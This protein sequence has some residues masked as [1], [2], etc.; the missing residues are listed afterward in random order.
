MK[1]TRDYLISLYY[2]LERQSGKQPTKQ[3]WLDSSSTPSDMPI[4]I[5]FGNWTNFVIACGRE[6]LKSEIS[7]KARLNSVKARKGK[8]GGNN[9]GGKYID[10]S[11]YVQI[12]NPNH[13]N[14]KS[15]GYMHEHRLVMS[16][17]LKRPLKK[18]EN[19]H[20]INGDRADNRIENLE[21]WTTTQPSGQ[22]VKD[23]INWA[24]EFLKEYG[25][26]VN[27][28]GNIYETAETEEN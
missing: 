10:K 2:D 13:P 8:K 4:R 6:P 7:I 26:E 23:K 18:Y 17:Y 22:R 5:R 25:Y 15:A 14:S 21:L 27:F 16:N 28:I 19:V 1:I 12:W 24:I 3:M 9:K 11:G 20:H